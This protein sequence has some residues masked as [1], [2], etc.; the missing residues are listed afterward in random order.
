MTAHSSEM[1]QP[2][3]IMLAF[4][5]LKLSDFRSSVRMIRWHSSTIMLCS[6]LEHD[7]TVEHNMVV[8][9]LISSFPQWGKPV[10]Q[11]FEAINLEAFPEGRAYPPLQAVAQRS[12]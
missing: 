6:M 8:V 12:Q 2:W 10:V 11:L 9:F 7:M 4:L 5:F 3:M 1:E